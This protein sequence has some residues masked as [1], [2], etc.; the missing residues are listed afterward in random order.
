MPFEGRGGELLRPMKPPWGKAGDGPGCACAWLRRLLPSL[1]VFLNLLLDSIAWLGSASVELVRV[2]SAYG[3]RGASNPDWIAGS[4]G[5]WFSMAGRPKPKRF[6]M[7]LI[8]GTGGASCSAPFFNEAPAGRLTVSIVDVDDMNTGSDISLFAIDFFRSMPCLGCI[9]LGL[10]AAA[11][12][13]EGLETGGVWFAEN[14]GTGDGRALLK[15]PGDGRGEI[16]R[17]RRGEAL[18]E[19]GPV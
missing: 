15:P 11:L 6:R 13:V 8:G 12:G 1:N 18:A 3:A 17:P 9:V 5:L 10:N 14:G 2:G 16:G 4:N 19:P 7:G